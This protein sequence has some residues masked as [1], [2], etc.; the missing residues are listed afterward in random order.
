[1]LGGRWLLNKSW[2]GLLFRHCHQY[3]IDLDRSGWANRHTRHAEYA[4]CLSHRIRLVGIPGAVI[5]PA[6]SW[7]LEPFEYS[8]GAD[9]KASSIAYAVVPVDGHESSVYP[10]SLHILSGLRV[11]C[12]YILV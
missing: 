4:V 7:V 10:Q 2:R 1:M 12:L 3:L 8:D 11:C 6:L 9:R 5:F